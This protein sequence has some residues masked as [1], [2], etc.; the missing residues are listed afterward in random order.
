MITPG[1]LATC[2]Q[3]PLSQYPSSKPP[4]LTS[5]V[6]DD[7]A[8]S[9]SAKSSGSRKR[10]VSSL[11]TEPEVMAPSSKMNNE[12]RLSHGDH[13][14][15]V[16]AIYEVGLK[17][18]SPAVILENMTSTPECI[19]SERVKSHLQKYRQNRVKAKEEFMASYDQWMRQVLP[20]ESETSEQQLP[21]PAALLGMMNK[22]PLGSG[23][24]AA[25]LTYSVLMNDT[26]IF[27]LGKEKA[28]DVD[29][30]GGKSSDDYMS[31][32]SSGAALNFPK[33][34][35]AEEKSSVGKAMLHVQSMFAA[36]TAQVEFQRGKPYHYQVKE[37]ARRVSTGFPSIIHGT[38]DS[39]LRPQR[40]DKGLASGVPNQNGIPG[41]HQIAQSLQG[42]D[43]GLASPVETHL[44][45]L[46][47]GPSDRNIQD[48]DNSVASHDETQC[49]KSENCQ[50][51]QRGVSHADSVAS[52][53][54]EEAKPEADGKCA[55]S[56]SNTSD[57]P[58]LPASFPIHYFPP[59]H[60]YPVEGFRP[61]IQQMQQQHS[62][63]LHHQHHQQ[64][65]Q[66]R[67]FHLNQLRLRNQAHL[68]S[69]YPPL[70]P[71]PP[72]PPGRFGPPPPFNHDRKSPRR[73][74]S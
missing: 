74:G 10:R 53:V 67:Q 37:S 65:Q 20:D 43:K 59:H 71:P 21:S 27:S 14:A 68:W 23:E 64:Q 8:S 39:A 70:P 16:E 73:N 42:S 5:G 69:N 15:L 52:D 31:Y 19:T 63:M 46:S 17:N 6:S 60:V 33:L 58:G 12:D 4:D 40:F 45:M 62:I 72:P 56:S 38:L 49:G 2:K 57:R 7:D 25:S 44:V 36:I 29:F 61:Q 13:R 34:T 3:T 18:A 51:D 54:G 24:M 48:N 11:G 50:T 55:A 30:Q 26:S 9:G 66:R 22:E 47:G 28:I 1:G 32:L 41:N 35:K